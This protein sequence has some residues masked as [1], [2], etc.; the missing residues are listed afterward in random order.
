M[1]LTGQN[2]LSVSELNRQV[3]QLLE[4]SFMQVL[5]SG[6]ISNFSCPSSGH[7]YFTLKDS[8][9]QVRCAMFRNRTLLLRGRPKNGDHVTLAAKVSLYEGRGEFQLIGET[10]EMAGEG[11]LRQAYEALR[12]KLQAEGLFDS[13]RKKPLPVLPARI[14]VITSPTGAAIR[15]ILTV[16]RRR[17]PAIPV[18]VIPVPVQGT[19]AAP[20]IVKALELANARQLCDLIILGRGGGSLEDLWAFNEETVVRAVAASRIPIICAVGHETDTTLSDFAA[21][22]RAPTPSAAAEKAS[23]DQNE[24]LQQLRITERRLISPLQRIVQGHRRHL[25]QL[26]TRLDSFA[27]LLEQKQLRL[28]EFD[29]R[30]GK[31]MLRLLGQQQREVTQ[32]SKRLKHPR[33]RLQEIGQQSSR[34]TEALQSAMQ[35]RLQREQLRANPLQHRLQRLGPL[36]MQAFD[37]RLRLLA[38]QLQAISPLATL[39]RGYS[40]TNNA[41]DQVLLSSSAVKAGD[42]LVTRL[43]E[44]RLYSCVTKVE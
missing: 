11:A 42:M 15:D 21:D 25:G 41:Q 9:A 26:E 1:N 5:V 18:L 37:H 24:W 7:W 23:P 27:R 40:I 19:E 17:F 12:L 6:E 10:L 32:A 28:D 34:L 30:L 35:R 38:G 13:S 20:A 29:S 43:H 22:L 36:L 31:A 4:A 39:A 14:G 44:G 8:H 33:V 3:R 2:P 16:L